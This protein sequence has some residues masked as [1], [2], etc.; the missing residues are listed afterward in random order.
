MEDASHLLQYRRFFALLFSVLPG[1]ELMY[2]LAALMLWLFAD[3]IG[4]EFGWGAGI[5]A[6]TFALTLAVWL[7]AGLGIQKW[8]EDKSAG[9]LFALNLPFLLVFF[10]TMGWL[11]YASVIAGHEPGAAEHS[12]VI[13]ETLRA[14]G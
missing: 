14:L 3:V 6:I 7:F 4:I 13:V 1:L 9:F 8:A 10:G 11:F 5:A 2:G 12:R